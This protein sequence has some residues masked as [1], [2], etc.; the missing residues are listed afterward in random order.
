MKSEPAKKKRAVNGAAKVIC[1]V[2]LTALLVCGVINTVR[3]GTVTLGRLKRLLGI[4][5]QPGPGVKIV[6][7]SVVQ[8]DSTLILTDSYSAL[9]DAGEAGSLGSIE[10]VLKKEG[11]GRLDAVF[12]T[13]P[14]LDHTG[15][16]SGILK[17]HGADR[18]YVADMAD[19]L[20]SEAYGYD[21]L[22]KDISSSG[23][24]LTV[25][26]TGDT[27][28]FA[29]GGDEAVLTVL[30]SGE[31]EDLNEASMVLRLVYKDSAA[32]FMA[33]T[34][35][36]AEEDILALKV[37]VSAQL[38]KVGHHGSRYS[39]SGDLLEAV[40]PV[41]AVISCG[42]DNEYGYPK[43]TVLYRLD[44]AGALIYR[45]DTMGSICAVLDGTGCTVR[46]YDEE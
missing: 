28:E 43:E 11:V 2:L 30:H 27:V 23:A 32:L 19:S 1:A 20:L 3:P 6:F 7:I 22:L 25:L 36:D 45:T 46:T 4:G 40:K 16:L 42:R 39:T 12:I 44:A 5:P 33:D 9:I 15:S 29:A 8:G 37:P 34:G 41:Y 38:L 14:H 31:G 35:F 26:K 10:E 24:G 17:R 18:V 13:H 21:R